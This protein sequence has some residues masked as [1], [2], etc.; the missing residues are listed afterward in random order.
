[1]KNYLV[2]LVKEG[3]NLRLY[4]EEENS[5][6]RYSKKHLSMYPL[7]SYFNLPCKWSSDMKYLSSGAR[8]V[9]LPSGKETLKHLEVEEAA[10]PV[11]TCPQFQR[12]FLSTTKMENNQAMQIGI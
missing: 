4:S 5:Y 11:Y 6:V 7:G 2:K 9:I 8:P 3:N 10:K 1:M 12:E